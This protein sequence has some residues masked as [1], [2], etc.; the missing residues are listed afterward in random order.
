MLVSTLFLSACSIDNEDESKEINTPTLTPTSIP[1]S[2][3]TIDQ[4]PTKILTPT[5]DSNRACINEDRYLTQIKDE[6]GSN[7]FPGIDKCIQM[8]IERAGVENKESNLAR[9]NKMKEL[10][11]LYLQEKEKCEK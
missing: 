1:T 9:A 2:I 4:T 11:Q 7:P 5:I 10:K 6:C 8:R 3:P